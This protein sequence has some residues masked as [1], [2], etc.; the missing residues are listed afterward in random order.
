[1]VRRYAVGGGHNF[2]DLAIAPAGDVYLTDTR[3][4]VVWYLAKGAADLTKLP[5]RFEFANGIALSPGG[6]LLY[7]STFPDGISVVDLKTHMVKP[8]ARPPDLCLATIDGLCSSF[9]HQREGPDRAARRH[10]TRRIASGKN[11]AESRHNGHIL[12]AFVRVGDGRRIDARAGLELPQRFA[13]VLVE[14]KE[15]ARQF[16][17]EHQPAAGRQH[18]GRTGQIGQGDLPFL[19]ARQ[20]I[21]RRE[22]T[23]DIARV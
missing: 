9:G 19:L 23:D 14:R 3:A 13:R 16:A 15:L 8:I 4:G 11:A 17:R 5:G 6:G 2:N 22:V 1:M 18:A 12:A 7:V 21:D 10:F 20:R